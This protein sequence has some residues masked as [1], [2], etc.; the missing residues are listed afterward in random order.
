MALEKV[1]VLPP[2]AEVSINYQQLN[3]S[4]SPNGPLTFTVLVEPRLT[5]TLRDNEASVEPSQS[6]IKSFI[7]VSCQSSGLHLIDRSGTE[8]YKCLRTKVESSMWTE[9]SQ[10]D[11]CRLFYFMSF[12]HTVLDMQQLSQFSAVLGFV[13]LTCSIQRW[14]RTGDNTEKTTLHP[15]E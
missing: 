2:E 1:A 7:S 4:Q 9:G 8:S 10:S 14:S 11:Y 5:A 12:L 6:V 15:E 13:L 3:E